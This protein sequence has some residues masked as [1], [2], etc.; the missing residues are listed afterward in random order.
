LSFSTL[1][2][3]DWDF[4]T[5]IDFAA[6]HGYAGIEVRGIQRQLDLT[7]C[8]E[9]E[10]PA[11][12]K[13][14]LN[15]MN[16]K[17]L[18]FVGLGSSST[19]HFPESAER[20]KN[21]DEGKRFIDLA[22]DIECS[23]VRVFPNLLPKDKTKEKTME[24]ISNGLLELGNH[25][26]GS[27]VKVLLETHGDLVHAEDVENVM[28]TATHEHVGLV[29]DISNM[30]TVTKEAPSEVYARLKKYIHHTHIKD[31]KL[32]DG[33]PQYVLLGNGDVPILEAISILAK[34]NYAGYYSF[35]WE[36]LWHPE[37]EEPEIALADYTRAMKEHLKY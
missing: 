22:N 19:L 32:V 16:D 11:A 12:R 37:I 33:K 17:G 21:I 20:A 3:L 13:Q 28:Q 6:R 14:T 27:N 26:K 25:C 23:Y 1:G 31:A 24:L 7:K 2:C 8:K 5:I 10:T 4:A 30:W 9:F 18:R 34:D 15:M 35:E 36:K 29:W